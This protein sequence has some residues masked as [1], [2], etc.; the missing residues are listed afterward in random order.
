M[1]TDELVSEHEGKDNWTHA[2]NLIRDYSDAFSVPDGVHTTTRVKTPKRT[3]LC[4]GSPCS[5]QHDNFEVCL[6][7]SFSRVIASSDDVLDTTVTSVLE[8]PTA[9]P[10]DILSDSLW[11]IQDGT[12]SLPI[13]RN[14]KSPVQ[15]NASTN[16]SGNACHATNILHCNAPGAAATVRESPPCK[17]KRSQ[18]ESG[19]G[20]NDCISEFTSLTVDKV[21]MAANEDGDANWRNGRSSQILS[22]CHNTSFIHTSSPTTTS[23]NPRTKLPPQSSLVSL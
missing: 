7:R 21:V 8:I 9:P 2:I 1:N 17:L 19:R 12:M 22:K 20:V 15:I 5:H 4:S 13:I 18:I 6:S 3:Y 23:F 10:R 16:T 14:Q 11:S